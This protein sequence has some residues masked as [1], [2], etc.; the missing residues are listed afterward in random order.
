MKAFLLAAGEGTRLWPLTERVP[1]CLV[2]IRGQPLLGLW[3]ALLRRHGI[4]EVLINLHWKAEQVREFL[5]RDSQGLRVCTVQEETLLG[6][7]GTLRASWRWVAREECFWICYADVLT[8]MNLGEMLARHRERNAEFTMGLVRTEEPHRCG[9]AEVEASGRIIS[10][11]EKPAQP[12]TNLAFA[13]V[14]LS[15][16]ALESYLPL[17]FPSDLGRDVFPRLAGRI[18][19]FE[20]SNYLLDIGTLANYQRAQQTWPGV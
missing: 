14:F 6:S 1:K 19:A 16:P 7:A 10:F 20:I 17:T 18:D 4:D 13:G 9:I 2:P 11:Q 8:N 15:T 5:A 3:L 12:R